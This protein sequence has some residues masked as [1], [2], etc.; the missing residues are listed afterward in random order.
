[1][2]EQL[3]FDLPGKPAL[4][5]DDF[6]VSPVNAAAVGTVGD[7]QNW[8]GG[9]LILIGPSGS[10]KTH[11]AHVWASE[12][13]AQVLSAGA[14]AP[15]AIADIVQTNKNIAIEDADQIA[16]NGALEDALFHLH[17][18][19][20]AQNGRLLVTASA[21][22]VRW[23]LGLAD[24]TS[25]MQGSNIVTLA[26]P[27]DPLLAAVL[28]KLFGD[29]QLVVAPK[30]VSYLLGRMERSFAGA[31]SLVAQLDRAALA[32]KRAITPALA[33]KVLDKLTQDTP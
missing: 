6:F 2:P 32:Q 11:L 25:R 9:K 14:I 16:G 29:R 30:V 10:G 17:N 18:L 1:M 22:P 5:R 27:D 33:A 13:N 26:P 20:L 28:V 19:V 8:P 23:G 21:P 15:P 31:Q 12:A 3:T 24:L 4:G 7:W